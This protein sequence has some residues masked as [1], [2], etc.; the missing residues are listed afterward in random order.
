MLEL[1]YNDSGDLTGA[2]QLATRAIEI[3]GDAPPAS[4]LVL[5]H[6]R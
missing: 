6:V 2:V 4:T 3:A 5:D 1:H